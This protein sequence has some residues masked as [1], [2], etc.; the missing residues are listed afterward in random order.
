MTGVQKSNRAAQSE[1]LRQ[2]PCGILHL[3]GPVAANVRRHREAHAMKRRFCV[4]TVVCALGLITFQ[5]TARAQGK[6]K[7]MSDGPLR[8]AFEQIT[9]PFRR[10][11][12]NELELV[13]GTSPVIHKRVADGEA[14]DLLV[15]QPY[16][17]AELAK[18]G[19]VAPGE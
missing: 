13:F 10:E 5:S 14:A 1:P 17:I 11:T 9:E 6:V 15:I 8:P 7:V 4:L 2:R 3:V 18:A 16:F 19:K 12:G